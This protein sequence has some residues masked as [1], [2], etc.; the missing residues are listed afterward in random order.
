MQGE[1]KNEQKNELKD[2]QKKLQEPRKSTDESSELNKPTCG[3]NAQ[4][5]SMKKADKFCER[6]EKQN[7]V[8]INS[9][10]QVHINK[11][12]N[13]QGNLLK[14]MKERQKQSVENIIVKLPVN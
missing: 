3:V 6:K 11:G 5:T 2:E 10:K 9:S 12:L 13:K 4:K 8:S 1:P 7:W 14:K